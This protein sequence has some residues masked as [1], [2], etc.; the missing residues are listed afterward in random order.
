MFGDHLSVD[1][2]RADGLEQVARNLPQRCATW[3]AKLADPQP[4]LFID[5]AI[6][7]CETRGKTGDG[8][9]VATP[10]SDLVDQLI[11]AT[12]RLR[13]KGCE[14]VLMVSVTPT[15]SMMTNRVFV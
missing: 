10:L 11:E 5:L 15:A 6:Q 4:V 7:R 8:I 13:S 9:E 14:I 3:N 12:L 1:D 2:I